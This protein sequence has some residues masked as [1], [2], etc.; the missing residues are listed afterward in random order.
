MT[1]IAWD[2]QILAADTLGTGGAFN[3]KV[4]KVHCLKDG[5][6]FAGAGDAQ[7]ILL[8]V[9]WLNNPKKAKP[10]LEDNF[11]G[12]LVE[13]GICYRLEC[14]LIKMPVKEKHHSVGSG[15]SFAITAMYLGQGAIEAVQ[16][17]SVFDDAT[18]FD[19]T[20]VNAIKI[21]VP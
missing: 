12:I 6:Y 16:T 7:D 3:R 13:C 11:V 20:Y 10:D 14:K 21:A 2:G 9:E 1:T 5:S 15:A 18:S 4:E 17:A 8:A 19:T